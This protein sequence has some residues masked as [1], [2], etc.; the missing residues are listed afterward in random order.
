MGKRMKKLAA[1]LMA[2]AM[3]LTTAACGSSG[4][5][6]TSGNDSTAGSSTNSTA[7]GSTSTA[8][9]ADA[10]TIKI[11]WWGND[12]RHALTKQVLDLYT[13]QNPNVTFETAPSGWDGYFESLSTQAAS[14]SMPDIVQMDYLYIS[15]YANNGTLADLT[16]YINDGTIDVSGIDSNILNSGKI[17]DKMAGLV[18]STSV[19]SVPYNPSVLADVGL[20]EPDSSWTWDDFKDYV[21]KIHE[22]TGGYGA[23]LD[24]IG[25]VNIFNYFVRQSGNTLFAA[26]NKSLGYSDDA[27]YVN[28]VNYWKDL[29]DAGAITNPDQYSTVS[30]GGDAALPIVK[31]EAGLHFGWNNYANNVADVN[32]T[33]KLATPPMGSNA[34]NKGLWLKPGMFF[35]IAETSKVKDEAAKF[36]NWFVTSTEVADII[37]TDRGTP[38]SADIRERLV[39]SGSLTA[40]QAEMFDY[41]DAAAL[42]SGDTPAP[43]PEGISEINS[44]FR[45]TAM[46][47][48]Y[49]ITS[50]EDAAEQ[51]R[52]KA[53]EILER[54]NK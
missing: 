20:A 48:F 17:G 33:L 11:A 31:N 24:P 44:A 25:D 50:A 37:G 8:A 4:A 46:S 26:D 16:P 36:L 34:S 29:M 21:L 35:S 27:V 19:Y 42:V 14:G 52:E 3:V 49:G 18:L 13:Q 28:F 10:V 32:D 47:V 45:D 38:V 15:T 23:T 41:V 12:S 22:K 43:D 6:E 51:F 7:S 5:S 9:S 39:G 30:E 40:K 53:N 2:G 1:L 54:N